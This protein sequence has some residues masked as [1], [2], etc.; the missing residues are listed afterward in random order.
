[1]RVLVNKSKDLEYAVVVT[2]DE[3]MLEMLYTLQTLDL[4]STSSVSNQSGVQ[5][6]RQLTSRVLS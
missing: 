3:L 1:M 4:P 5:L 2:G 6:T